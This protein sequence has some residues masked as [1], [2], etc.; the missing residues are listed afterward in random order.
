[1]KIRNTDKAVSPVIGTIL[2]VVITVIIAAIVAVFAF[3]IGTPTKAPQV[4]LQM[5]ADASTDKFTITHSGGDP[6]VTTN[7][8]I[9]MVWA[10]NTANFVNTTGPVPIDGILLSSFL[11]VQTLAPGVTATNSSFTLVN[12]NDIIKVMIMDVPSGQFIVNTQVSVN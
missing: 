12:K 2:M 9:T 11:G 4:N 7:E 10:N 6:L 3:G 5:S 1:M 8:K